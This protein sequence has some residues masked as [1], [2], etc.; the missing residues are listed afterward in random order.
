MEEF[1]IEQLSYCIVMILGAI[2]GLFHVVQK[3]RCTKINIC[4][5]KCDRE[6]TAEETEL[7][8][9]LGGVSPP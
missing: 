4:G 2:G 5:M 7:E 8:L 9:P 3:S 1:S 6:L